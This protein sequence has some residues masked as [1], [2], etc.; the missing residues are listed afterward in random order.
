MDKGIFVTATDTGVGKTIVSSGLAGAIKEKGIDVGI[1]KPA[2]TGAEWL[3]GRLIS[4]DVRFLMNSINSND[5][6][7]LVCPVTLKSPL[8]P[9]AASIVD[10]I[11]I[12]LSRIFDAFDKMCKIHDFVVVEG[13][14]GILAPIKE[15]YFVSDLIRDFK[16]P[17]L[18]VTRPGL[19]T[20]NHTLLTINEMKRRRI[21]LKGF[22]INGLENEK[23]GLAEKMNP[24]LI[25]RLSGVHLC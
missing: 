2:V 16:L 13:I 15:N 1:M 12:N 4:N 17:S 22:I 11:E 10:N 9:M 5:D 7:D 8:A 21:D 24:E 23:A 3:N 20:I 6:P 25:K 14:G 18:I 19:G